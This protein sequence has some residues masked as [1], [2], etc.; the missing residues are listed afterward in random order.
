M[1]RSLRAGPLPS[2]SLAAESVAPVIAGAGTGVSSCRP[3]LAPGLSH[4]CGRL[5]ELCEAR[6][7]LSPC[8]FYPKEPYFNFKQCQGAT[9]TFDDRI[10]AVEF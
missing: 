1:E 6:S 2:F 5:I 4:L 8:I 10:L 3:L 9:S 7:E